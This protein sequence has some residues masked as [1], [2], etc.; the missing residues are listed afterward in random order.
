MVIFENTS[1]S[2]CVDFPWVGVLSF[3]TSPSW[4]YN[5]AEMSCDILAGNSLTV[6]GNFGF[7]S[8]SVCC[9][10][11]TLL[12]N[13]FRFCW[14]PLLLLFCF[15]RV[16]MVTQHECKVHSM[17]H[18]WM[19]CFMMEFLSVLSCCALFTISISI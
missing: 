14:N 1:S 19:C 11:M 7:K 6:Y 2:I 10:S 5:L 17:W 4:C 13:L 18:L 15:G 16:A 12:R 9:Y 3:A 8:L